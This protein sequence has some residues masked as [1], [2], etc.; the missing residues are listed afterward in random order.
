MRTSFSY[1]RMFLEIIS[2]ISDFPLLVYK[3]HRVALLKPVEP[4]VL[5]RYRRACTLTS[6]IGRC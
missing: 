4:D 2:M 6:S 5:D 1:Q 3:N